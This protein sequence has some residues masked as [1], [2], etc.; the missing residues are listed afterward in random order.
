M[1]FR[2]D[3]KKKLPI[4]SFLFALGFSKEKIIDTFYSTNKYTFNG[5]T[6]SWITDFDLENYKR[7]LKLS[8]DLVDAKNKKKFRYR[9]KKVIVLQ[10]KKN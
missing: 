10:K 7:P 8:Y 4:T 6:K 3:R 2:I 9:R 5:E 1:Y